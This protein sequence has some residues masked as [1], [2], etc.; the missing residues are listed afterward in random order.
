[1][2]NP[3]KDNSDL[4]HE[5]RISQMNIMQAKSG[6]L[7]PPAPNSS[8]HPITSQGIPFPMNNPSSIL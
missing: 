1:M 5:M 7:L 3:I 6:L 8:P 2:N 4:L